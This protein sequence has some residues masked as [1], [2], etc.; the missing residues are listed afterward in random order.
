MN[1]LKFAAILVLVVIGAFIIKTQLSTHQ[2]W[3]QTG[4]ISLSIN[5]NNQNPLSIASMRQKSYPGSNLTIEQT[6]EGGSNYHQYIASYMSDGLKIYGLLTVPVGD[7][8]KKYPVIVFNHGYIPPMV[9]KTTQRYVAYVDVFARNGYIVFK[10]D[11]RGHDNSQGN[12]EGAYYSPGY[13]TD[14]L[15]ALATLKKYNAADPNRIGMW[16]HSMG[17]NI[18]LRT[19][20]VNT[21]DIKAA[22]LW[23]AVV[24]SY[25]DLLNNWRRRT[26]SPPPSQQLALRN[27]YRENLIRKYGTPQKNPIFWNS[28]DPTFFLSDVTTPIQL[29]TGGDD[30]EVPPEFS[31]HLKDTLERL[32]KPVEYYTYPGGDHNISSP[33]FEFAMQK[34]VDFFD[35]YLKGGEDK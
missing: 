31:L 20:V 5:Q 25:N 19:L 26:L 35:K 8:S 13:T 1:N 9:Y 4:N 17:G 30:E 2:S 6:L 34:S 32:G 14:V 7:D 27:R 18:T 24:G 28:I 22:V 29:H 3:L 16:G 33:N 15:N 11:Y 10:P 12:P 23:G 21:K